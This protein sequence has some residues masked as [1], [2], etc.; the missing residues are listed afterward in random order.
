MKKCETCG[1]EYS[2][3]CDWQQGRCPHHPPILAWYPKYYLRY[4]NIVELI[5]GWWHGRKK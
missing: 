2:S 4:F 5:K 1:K 3:A